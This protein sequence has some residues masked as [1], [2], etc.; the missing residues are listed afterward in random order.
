MVETP[1]KKYTGDMMQELLED[2]GLERQGRVFEDELRRLDTWGSL[3]RGGLGVKVLCVRS[4]GI[5]TM[6]RLIFDK[7][8]GPNVTWGNLGKTRVEYDKKG[9][10]IVNHSSLEGCDP[11]A[12][13][14]LEL[15]GVG[16]RQI[17]ANQGVIDRVLVEAMNYEI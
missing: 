5:R 11:F 4:T 6:S 15:E 8:F 1:S 7:D 17:L 2:A 13:E 12:D 10:G 14:V 3:K 16:H 9:D